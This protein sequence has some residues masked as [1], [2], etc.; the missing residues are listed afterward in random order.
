MYTNGELQRYPRT[1]ERYG[2]S[3]GFVPFDTT[4]EGYDKPAGR[5][6]YLEHSSNEWV[7][8]DAHS[9]RALIADLEE[10]LKWV[11]EDR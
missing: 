10:A 6:V 3:A 1:V 11:E 2:H 9:I 5:G 4:T 7:I 8:G